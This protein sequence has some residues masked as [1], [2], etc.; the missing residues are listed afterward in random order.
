MSGTTDRGKLA[1]KVVLITGAGAG[2]GRAMALLFAQEGATIVAADLDG[3]TAA[4]TIGQVREASGRDGLALTADVSDPASVQ[5]MVDQAIAHF[6]RIDV[7]CNNAGIGS[8]KDVID[9]EPDEWDQVFAVNVRGVFLGCKYTLPHMLVQGGGVIINSASV[10]GLVGFP[11]RA[12]YCASKGAVVML[13]KQI[14]VEFAERGIRC[15]CICPGTLDSPWVDRV[16]AEAPDPVAERRVL[17][18]RH[19]VGRLGTP[20]EV[21]KAALYL[22]SEDAAFISG[23]A[24]VIDGGLVAR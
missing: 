6:G 16:L 7:L 19:P 23:T 14:A 12:A 8:T 5:Q 10:A 13:T 15:N 24:L 3:V 18:A 21:A 2:I 22:A 1:G 17:E 20:E 11:K 4:E 9:T